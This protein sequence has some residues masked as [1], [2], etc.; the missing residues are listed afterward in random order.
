MAAR[1]PSTGNEAGSGMPPPRLMG[2]SCSDRDMTMD[3]G[4]VPAS[5]GL[6]AGSIAADSASNSVMS[7]PSQWSAAMSAL[8]LTLVW[9]NA[10]LQFCALRI[11]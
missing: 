7:C 1:S 4:R 10:M 9:L 3:R 5:V 11:S 8:V 6:I 2:D